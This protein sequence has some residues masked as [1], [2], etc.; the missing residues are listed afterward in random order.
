MCKCSRRGFLKTLGA[1]GAAMALG[2]LNPFNPLP[3]YAVQSGPI[4]VLIQANGGWDGLHVTPV[5]H[6]SYFDQRPNIA[7]PENQQLDLGHAVLGL[8]P[9]L[10]NLHTRFGQGDLAIIEQ[11]A[12]ADPSLSHADSQRF[13]SFGVR[14]DSTIRTGWLGRILDL[15]Q[16]QQPNNPFLGWSFAGNVEVLAASNYTATA[17]GDLS[18][19]G[20]DRD[21]GVWGPEDEYRHLLIQNGLQGFN[22]HNPQEERMLRMHRGIYDALEAVQNA[23]DQYGNRP[24]AYPNTWLARRMSNIATLVDAGLGSIFVVDQG[25]YD[26]HGEQID[27]GAELLGELDGAVGAFLADMTARNK[28]RDVI[29]LMMGEFGRNTYENSSEGTDHG[30]GQT[31]LVAGGAVR[32]GIYGSVPS[33]AL[34]ANEPY[35]GNEVDIRNI[36]RE[37]AGRFGFSESQVL[38]ET[39]AK[40][41]LDIV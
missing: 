6:G 23:E 1:G 36:Y 5:N 24:V 20:F 30:I 2:K 27:R 25:G 31:V 34:I 32:G 35:L 7:I 40:I 12:Y 18:D 15:K 33:A 39:Y 28:Y 41:A 19:F 29:V 26:T 8:H 4:L 10:S 17:A 11:A 37:I 16:A 21:W 14:N 3:A 22:S 38:P 13:V 9:S